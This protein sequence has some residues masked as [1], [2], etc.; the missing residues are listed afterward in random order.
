M[1]TI[2]RDQLR[3]I[4]AAE[5]NERGPGGLQEQVERECTQRGLEYFHP[6]DSRRSRE[7]WPDMVIATALDVIFVELKAEKRRPT[8]HQYK[9]LNLLTSRGQRC[10]LWRPINLL[11]GTIADVLVGAKDHDGSGR[12]V[13][14]HG[15][16]GDT[17]SLAGQRGA[18]T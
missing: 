5:M 10:Y 16:V 4:Q 2:T 14:G 12:W 9:W 15:V 3:E 1:T 13:L 11:N 17:W 8:E 18:L 7:G 6:Y